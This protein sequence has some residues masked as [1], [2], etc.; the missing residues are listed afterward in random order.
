V[1]KALCEDINKVARF[2]AVKQLA[3]VNK[4]LKMDSVPVVGRNT[5]LR[6]VPSDDNNYDIPPVDFEG[7]D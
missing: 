2:I 3:K 4:V 1:I 6:R 7:K 5:E